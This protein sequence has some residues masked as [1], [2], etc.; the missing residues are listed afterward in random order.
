MKRSNTIGDSHLHVSTA[1]QGDA[2]MKKRFITGLI[3]SLIVCT[4]A[5]P[6]QCDDF[7]CRCWSK[8]NGGTSEDL[9][10]VWGTSASNIYA[11]GENSTILHFDGS[12]WKK[13]SSSIE[14]LAEGL[15]FYSI[16]GSSAENVYALG[17]YEYFLYL[18]DGG[19]NQVTGSSKSEAI[20]WKGS[21]IYIP[22]GVWSDA[23]GQIFA[24]DQAGYIFHRGVGTDTRKGE[25]WV[26]EHSFGGTCY[27]VWVNSY[28][29][30]FALVYS[31]NEAFIPSYTV[32]HYD[33]SG[34]SSVSSFYAAP[35]MYQ[36]LWADS[37]SN[38][39]ISGPIGYSSRYDGNQW[40]AIDGLSGI[41]Y[42]LWG[43]DADDIYAVGANGAISHYNG[44][45]WET[46]DSGASNHLRALWGDGEGHVFAVG[47]GGT[48]LRLSDYNLILQTWWNRYEFKLINILYPR[49]AYYEGL[50]SYGG[51]GY[52]MVYDRKL[53]TITITW[54]DD[55]ADWIFYYS[56]ENLTYP[57]RTDYYECVYTLQ[58]GGVGNDGHFI[59]IKQGKLPEKFSAKVSQ[60]SAADYSL[61]YS[62]Q[63]A[64]QSSS[65]QQ[66]NVLKLGAL[67]PLSGG[68]QSMGEAFRA[69]LT[70]AE[71]DAQSYLSEIGSE[72]TV[73]LLTEDAQTD[74]GKTWLA[75][76]D[77]R[78]EGVSAF[79]GPQ[80]S[81]S[82]D[83]M[84]QFA[85]E[86]GYLLLS[87]VST[88]AELSIPD[89]NVMR[90]IGDDNLQAAALSARMKAD[91]V[92][93]IVVVSRADIYGTGMYQALERSWLADNAQDATG[94]G[95]YDG[96]SEDKY[97]ATTILFSGLETDFPDTIQS[98]QNILDESAFIDKSKS[99]VVLVA[100][101][102]A[103]ELM[104]Q[105][106]QTEGMDGV[107]WYGTD[108]LAQNAAVSGDAEAAA[109]AAQTQ[110]TCSTFFVPESE[111]NQN[112]REAIAAELGYEAPSMAMLVYDSYQL[113]V[114][115]YLEAGSDAPESMKAALQN[116]AQIYQGVTGDLTFN[117]N[118]DRATGAY[119]YWTLAEEN[120][121][122]YWQSDEGQIW[123]GDPVTVE[124]WMMI[125]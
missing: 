44:A 25:K 65:P 7:E 55:G 24:A 81:A 10:G 74:P 58:R 102:E 125:H 47:D 28:N 94:Y 86:E 14:D 64:A 39:I 105:A 77:L 92:K 80:D 66:E 29:D 40:T 3:V 12:D 6:S 75:V 119:Q 50:P 120:G 5:G 83:Y 33:G 49:F 56:R 48:V 51:S 73:E 19:W 45:K 96:E 63:N 108:S 1:Q 4:F 8:M 99:A 76:Q 97:K 107:R 43:E 117:A 21:S 20:A 95:L 35:S 122:Y 18:E 118:G 101:E 87:G 69:A 17:R 15:S 104:K 62:R 98:L 54:I 109:F 59:Y 111:A 124:D 123:T 82:L 42:D 71:R 116:V 46:M 31:L 100:Y 103:A 37:T 89:D 13:I 30:I 70:V 113:A 78:N 85:D 110:F 114:R 90:C 67:L 68:L 52:S 34:W 91:G 26:L 53:D 121:L 22:I 9:W 106:A 60:R 11:V 93:S 72:L 32:Y 112:V 16:G 79:L 36:C 115:A 27:D 41:Y 88:A 61:P 2:R 38:I 84:K 57:D 23:S